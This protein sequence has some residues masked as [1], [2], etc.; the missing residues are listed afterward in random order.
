MDNEEELHPLTKFLIERLGSHPEEF[1]VSS[2][3]EYVNNQLTQLPSSA[4]DI[5]GR[6]GRAVSALFNYG[7]EKDKSEFKKVYNK[8]RMDKAHE[9]AMDELFNGEERRAEEKRLK[10]EAAKKQ[11]AAAHAQAQNLQ[12]QID[13]YNQQAQDYRA[14]TKAIREA[15]EKEIEEL[16]KARSNITSIEK[17]PWYK[18]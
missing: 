12:N 16:R 2:K 9:D 18:W 15:T 8:T 1:S 7:S 14:Q 17:K 4:K 11:A 6:W 5:S 13:Y 10:N 3:I